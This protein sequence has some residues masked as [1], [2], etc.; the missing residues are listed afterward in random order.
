VLDRVVVRGL[1]ASVTVLTA[2]GCTSGATSVDAASGEITVAATTNAWG[3][4]LAQLGGSRVREVSIINNP[5]TDP[6]DYEPTPA[7]ARTMATSSVFVENGVGYDAWAD[8]ALDANPASGRIVINVGT[9]VG[10]PAGGNPHRWY[11]PTDVETAAG[12]ITAALEKVDPAGA[13][14]FDQQHQT[15][16]TTGLG[17]YRRLIH[18]IRST[19]AGVPVGASESIFAPLAE[20]LG[21]DLVTPPS[22]LR[23]ISEGIDPSS[24]DKATIDTQIRDRSIKIYVINS[25]NSTPDVTAQVEA[26]KAA[27]IPVTSI[28]ETLTPANATFQ[29]WQVAQLHALQAA[30]HE[31]TGR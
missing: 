6:H 3:S 17:D 16:M 11:S 28:T 7:D 8:R 10:V 22:F 2:G 20:A 9:V 21:L 26:A 23:A 13:A 1:L 14:Y 5:N 4:V 12:A 18:R 19:Y 25:Q 15:F 30:L 31:A 27:G 29:H 24:A